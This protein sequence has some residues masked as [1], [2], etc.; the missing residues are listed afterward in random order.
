MSEFKR[1]M[2]LANEPHA[3]Y[4]DISSTLCENFDS[5]SKEEQSKTMEFINKLSKSKL[6]Y[7]REFANRLS[8]DLREALRKR[9]RKP[10]GSGLNGLLPK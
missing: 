3:D 1:F 9:K 8:R 7:E 2:A 5:F 10:T 4:F 6:D